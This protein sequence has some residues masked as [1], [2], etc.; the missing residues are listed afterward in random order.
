MRDYHF[1][2]D[3][4]TRLCDI[5]VLNR[6]EQDFTREED[7]PREGDI[8]Q[9]FN[10]KY[11]INHPDAHSPVEIVICY[12]TYHDNPPHSLIISTVERGP[13]R[14]YIRNDPL[15]FSFPSFLFQSG[16][17][18]MSLA[19]NIIVFF[20]QWLFLAATL[21][22]TDRQRRFDSYIDSF[23]QEKHR[24]KELMYQF[25]LGLKRKNRENLI[26]K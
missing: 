17:R 4:V 20:H 15:D 14:P 24:R 6:I 23:I 22:L 1:Y 26:N 5:G 16:Q 10:L 3:E 21:P 13:P 7:E 9:K 19:K 18:Y 11:S 8:M 2:V 25:M 12:V